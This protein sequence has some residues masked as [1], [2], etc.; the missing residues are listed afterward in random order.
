[1]WKNKIKKAAAAWLPLLLFLLAAENAPY[2]L[3]R[4]TAAPE[5]RGQVLGVSTVNI[6]GELPTRTALAAVS[7]PDTT[8][9]QAASFLVFDLQSGQELLSRAPDKQVAIAS[10]TKLMTAWVAYSGT[11]LNQTITITAADRLDVSPDLDLQIGDKVPALDVFNAMLIGS[12]ND[13]ALA[14][15]NFITAQTGQSAV[16]LMNQA[17]Q[18]LGMAETHFANPMGFDSADNYSSA[19]DL[20]K[21][22]MQTEQLAVFRNLGRRTSYDFSGSTGRHYHAV[23]TN[24]LLSSHPELAAI[25]TGSTPQ[26]AEAMAARFTFSGRDV[27]I[28]VLSSPDREADLLKLENLVRQNF[29][30]DN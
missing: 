13:A 12:C 4:Q 1:M 11:N 23:A 3:L 2:Q 14:L 30:T 5:K 28:L 22:I 24:R 15:G 26:A 16:E 18:K 6:R 19:A 25:K 9:V 17:A 20:K 8:K 10:L 21:L 7:D 27:A 29:K